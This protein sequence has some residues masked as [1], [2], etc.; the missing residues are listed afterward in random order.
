MLFADST[1]YMLIEPSTHYY[2]VMTRCEWM[3]VLMG[4]R[5]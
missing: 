2:K 3:P 5:I 4:E 1:P